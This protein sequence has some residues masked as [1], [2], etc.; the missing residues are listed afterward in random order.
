MSNTL[1]ITYKVFDIFLLNIIL[2]LYYIN[3]ILKY[4]CN[5]EII[6]CTY[7]N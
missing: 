5:T 6:F 4:L 3:I 7:K 1:P 2:L